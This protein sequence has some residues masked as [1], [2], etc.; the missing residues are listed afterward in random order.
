M[1]TA[2]NVFPVINVFPAINVF[3]VMIP[4]KKRTHTS[5]VNQQQQ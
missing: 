2:I 3:P 5:K 4:K 1:Q